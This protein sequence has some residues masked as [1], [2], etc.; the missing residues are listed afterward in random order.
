MAAHSTTDP[1]SPWVVVNK[2]HPLRPMD[3]RPASLATVAGKQ[4]DARIAGD[5]QALLAAADVD[6]VP[7]TLVSGYRSYGYQAEVHQRV[8]DAQGVTHAE[9]VSARAGHS[10]HQTGLAVDFGGRTNPACDLADCFGGTPE[11]RWLAEHA[12]GHGFL[13]RY[14]AANSHLTGYSGEAWHFRWVGVDLVTEMA[15]RQVGTLEE[16]FG[17]SGGPV[18]APTTAR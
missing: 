18:Y 8:I 5:L 4:V 9:N 7:L 16:F 6:G 13:L 14:T 2:Q 17:I 1:A 3:H 15:T 12:A 11:G 10:E